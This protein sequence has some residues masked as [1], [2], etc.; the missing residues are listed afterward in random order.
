MDVADVRATR[1]AARVV[2]SLDRPVGE[3]EDTTLGALL[4][5]DRARAR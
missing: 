5:S 1:D 4:P 2:T 3:E